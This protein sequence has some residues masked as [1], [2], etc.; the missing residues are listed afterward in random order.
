MCDS[1][2]YFRI[3]H[4]VQSFHSRYIFLPSII[5]VLLC[6]STHCYATSGIR[7]FLPYLSIYRTILLA[8]FF[9]LALPPTR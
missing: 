1:L 4:R 3:A 5:L 8:S 7:T 9:L 6:A 2:A